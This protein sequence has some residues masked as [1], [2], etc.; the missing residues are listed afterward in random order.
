MLKRYV[1]LFL[2]VLVVFI[3]PLLFGS[4][5]IKPSVTIRQPSEPPNVII[6]LV[7][8]M[9]ADHLHS[10]GYKY[11]TSPF[12]D[13]LAKRG[14]LFSRAYSQSSHTRISVASIMTGKLP[15]K[16][17]VR[18]GDTGVTGF[19]AQRLEDENTTLAELFK[20]HGYKT[21]YFDTNPHVTDQEGFSQGFDHYWY[22][23]WS[24]ARSTLITRN[25][26]KYMEEN[27]D[28]TPY[29]LHI[30]YMDVHNPYKPPAEFHKPFTKG[31][32]ELSPYYVD[33]PIR[34]KKIPIDRIKY[35]EALYNGEILAWDDAFRRLIHT[36]KTRGWLNNTLV[37]VLA[38]HGDEFL[39]H[40]GM[41]HGFTL[42]EEMLH[43]PLI[44]VGQ[45]IIPEG[46][47]RED[48]VRL[49]DIFPTLCYL[50]NIPIEGP[51]IQGMNLFRRK[52]Q[53]KA[54]YPVSYA[55]TWKGK[56][57]KAVR[58]NL[59]QLIYNAKPRDWEL[60]D[61]I[62]DPKQQHNIYRPGHPAVTELSPLLLELMQEPD[63]GLSCLCTIHCGHQQTRLFINDNL[64]ISRNIS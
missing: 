53:E 2:P 31:L 4:S 8:A 33:G 14:V 52:R 50:A 22:K 3:V 56:S 12:L 19:K 46:L 39:E 51:R 15:P 40:G 42:Y 64:S 26:I 49:I 13:S 10:Y 25:V 9:R 28:D 21:A 7:D 37:V 60:Y 35:S 20:D 38:D 48:P 44:L 16:N 63:F 5:C 18:V 34:S 58:T 1:E 59:Y 41:G 43:V 36:F 23:L 27:I 54:E 6:A 57:P 55:E 45:G 30:H 62:D 24:Q 29:F 11:V 17:N 32:K 61:L 47:V